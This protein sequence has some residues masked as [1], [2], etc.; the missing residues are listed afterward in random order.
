VGDKYHS[1]TRAYDICTS[2]KQLF[3]DDVTYYRTQ[4]YFFLFRL[5]RKHSTSLTVCCS[6]KIFCSDV[7]FFS[8]FFSEP[9][10]MLCLLVGNVSFWS[11]NIRMRWRPSNNIYIYNNQR[12]FLNCAESEKS[13]F[14]RCL[15]VEKSDGHDQ[16]LRRIVKAP[17]R[18][19]AKGAT[20]D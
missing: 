11:Q 14:F 18:R 1:L 19:R 5:L 4:T 10:P 8:W 17:I 12:L 13:G 20:T 9:I 16:K 2:I 6:D 7:R 15:Y 3:T